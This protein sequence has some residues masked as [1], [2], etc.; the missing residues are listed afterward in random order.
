MAV[1]GFDRLQR[2]WKR[3]PELILDN[4][5]LAMEKMAAEIVTEM[6]AAAP[7][8]ETLAL[9]NSIGWTWGDAPAGTMTIGA[10]GGSEYGTMRITIYAG[11][12][13]AFYAVYQEHGTVRMP[14]NPY[15]FPVW[16]KKKRGWKRR[17]ANAVKAAMRAA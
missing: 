10:V 16:R 11:G 6:R 17:M 12:G 3:I 1:E 8:G 15:F 9:V 4:V 7:K 5:R 2:R 13:D 14:A